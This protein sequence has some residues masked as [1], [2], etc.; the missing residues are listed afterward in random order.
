MSI[1]DAWEP[2][3]G[4]W[5]EHRD[6]RVVTNGIARTILVPAGPDLASRV[7]DAARAALRD[8]PIVVGAVPFDES[9]QAMLVVPGSFEITDSPPRLD[10]PRYAERARTD[11]IRA[12]PQSLRL[13]A[14]PEP[15]AYR[16][17]VASAVRAIA[18]GE[19]T[20]V[21]LARMLIAH[22]SRAFDRRALI[23]LL[24]AA[25]PDAITFAVQG[26]IGATPELLVDRRGASV[27]SVP[28]AGTARRRT[29]PAE[30]EAAGRALLASAKDRAEHAIV[31]DTIADDLSALCA[32]LDVPETP[33]LQPTASLWHLATPIEGTLADPATTALDL[34]AAMH[35]TPAVCGA[36][37]DAALGLIR[38]LEGF[39]RTL[40]AGAVGWM[41]AD[42]D[43]EW[44]IALRC[45]EVRGRLAMLFAGAGIVAG[46]DPDLELAE[47]DAKLQP[48]L[49]ALERC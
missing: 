1:L 18:D 43:G 15:A 25:E 33:V 47:T 41:T 5:F 48:M 40:Y 22:G 14:F 8:A 36:P 28:L 34:V 30:D 44:A 37:R 11:L 13:E 23:A 19:V 31:A 6:R 27:R 2:D 35:P 10:E 20:K 42:G 4:T 21:V 46:S 26:M 24:R 7:A 3:E 49:R 16:D 17:A 39:D 12:A 9:T 45:A 32:K 38:R 29:D